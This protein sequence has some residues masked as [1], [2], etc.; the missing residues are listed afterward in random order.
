MKIS[1]QEAAKRLKRGEVVAVPTETVYGLAAMLDNEEAVKKIFTLKGRPQDNPLIVHISDLEALKGLVKNVPATFSKVASFW[2]GPLTVVF[3]ADVT[4]VPSVVRAGLLTVG[5]R[6]PALQLTRDLIA[7]TGPLVAPSA[8]VSGRPSATMPEHVEADFGADFPV[9]DGG[10]CLCGVESTIVSLQDEAWTCLRSGAISREDLAKVFGSEPQAQ[11]FS[12]KPSSPGQKYRHYAPHCKLQLCASSEE[13]W[14]HQA[15]GH[16]DA[17][18]GFS[19]T[20]TLL[21]L[22][23]LGLKGDF[24]ENLKHLYAVLRELD[25]K[26]CHNVLVDVDFEASGLGATL[27]DR[28]ERAAKK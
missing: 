13:L 1:L 21:P 28:L 11:V 23:S 8:N 17:V 19:E 24:S 6:M 4:R 10:E 7:L 15:S 27:K 2:P 12:N 14:S 20:K 9:L 26:A 5:V 22:F 18:L 25:V 16:F 3:D